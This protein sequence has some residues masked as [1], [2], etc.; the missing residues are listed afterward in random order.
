MPQPSMAIPDKNILSY[1]YLK[2]TCLFY[3]QPLLK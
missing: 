3:I 2:K 1:H